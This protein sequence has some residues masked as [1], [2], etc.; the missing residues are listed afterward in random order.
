MSNEGYSIAVFST[1]GNPAKRIA[2]FFKLLRIA[3]HYDILH[4]HCCSHWGMLPVMY[5]VIAGKIWR[6]RMI[7]TYHGGGADEY[8]AKHSR[9]ARRW[10]MRADKVIVL[11]GYLK[12]VFEKYAIPC[13]VIPN[14]I[15][16][17]DAQTHSAYQWDA[18]RLISVRHLDELYNISCVLKAYAKI[19]EQ[20]PRAT[21][22][23]LS[24]GKQRTELERWVQANGLQ[25][26]QF[27]GQVDNR[28]IG[29][30]LAQS[31][32]L[33]SAPHVDNMPVSLMEAMKAG[34]LVVSSCVGGVPYM[35]TGGQNGLLFE[36]DDA[37]ELAQKV[38]QAIKNPMQAEHMIW[39]AKEDV[40]QYSWVN[41]RKKLLSIYG[42]D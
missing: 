2:L 27:V 22:T 34:V 12:H 15:N 9:F 16:N 39:Q 31:D 32:I 11:N 4:I 1:K 5:G 42:H 35:I 33:L 26:V 25:D 7:V 29:N 10:L 13:V 38:V 17:L 14:I 21:L 28:D 19:K 41:I 23:I 36:D 6:Q 30:Y 3:K 24:D 40:N 20:S 18:P 8:F 37:D